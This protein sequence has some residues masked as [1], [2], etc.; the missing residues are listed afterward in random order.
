MTINELKT[1]ASDE[2]ETI[3]NNKRRSRAERMR[4]ES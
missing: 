4:G 2:N 3:N 1:E